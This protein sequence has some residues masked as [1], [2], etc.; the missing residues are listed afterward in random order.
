[1][2]F[3]SISQLRSDIMK[4]NFHMLLTCWDNYNKKT[5]AN[6][7]NTIIIQLNKNNNTIV[8][9]DNSSTMLRVNFFIKYTNKKPPGKGWFF[10]SI[11]YSTKEEKVFCLPAH[12]SIFE[13][14]WRNTF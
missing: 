4:M 5:Y 7:I 9:V 3:D 2:E 11:L 1:M 8:Y 10:V 12:L 14:L 13:R 6:K